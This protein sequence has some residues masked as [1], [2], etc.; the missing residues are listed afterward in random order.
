MT[1]L[2]MKKKV[3]ALIE[4]LNPDSD[5]LT[6]DPDIAAKINYVINQ[7]MLELV[8]MK[9]LAKYVE[10]DVSA[11]DVLTFEE[12]GKAVGYD[13]Y[14]LATVS[15]AKHAAR[16]N[17][18]V[19]KALEDGVLEIDCYVYPESITDKTKDSYEFELSADAL[20]IMPYGIAADL[21]RSDIS[22]EYGAIYSERF[23]AM[24]ARLDPRNSIPSIC[25][26]GGV[27]I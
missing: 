2:E 15:G 4:E 17:N 12:I 26:K 14:Q 5:V 8:R 21:L 27:S 16:A 10:I 3:L 1:L 18:T 9:K 13:V 7:V 24:L 22:A 23:E 19:I 20:E 11:G 25:F 6:D